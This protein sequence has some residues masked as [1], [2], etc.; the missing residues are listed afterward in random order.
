MI[1]NLNAIE[2]EPNLYQFNIEYPLFLKIN[3]I[4]GD[5]VELDLKYMGD[6]GYYNDSIE[7]QQ[8][9][10]FLFDTFD[11]SSLEEFEEKYK[12]PKYFYD[13]SRRAIVNLEDKQAVQETLEKLYTRLRKGALFELRTPYKEI[14]KDAYPEN[15][16]N[17]FV[18]K[19]T[20]LSRAL[21][22]IKNI[23]EGNK[24]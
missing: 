2:V 14:L 6:S 21:A 11:I 22:K 10:E 17:L 15:V 20:R 4:K 23:K 19:E 13:F 18:E 7:T 12:N 9:L 8:H 5:K 3:P 1:P 16:K 24:E